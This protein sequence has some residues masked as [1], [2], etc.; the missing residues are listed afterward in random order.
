MGFEPLGSPEYQ[1][2]AL[3]IEL[4]RL[5]SVHLLNFFAPIQL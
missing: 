2:N 3:P 4:S 5:G 1:V